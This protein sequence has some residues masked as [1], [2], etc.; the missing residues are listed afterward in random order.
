MKRFSKIVSVTLAWY[1]LRHRIQG[2]ELRLHVG[3]K[4]RVLGGSESF[5]PFDA[6]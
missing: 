4:A 5:A 2:H 3:G 1:L 6:A